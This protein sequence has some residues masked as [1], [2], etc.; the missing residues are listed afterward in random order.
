MLRGMKRRMEISSEEEMLAEVDDDEIIVKE[1]RDEPLAKRARTEEGSSLVQ[2]PQ[3]P[4]SQPIK[5]E[6]TLE[7]KSTIKVEV[8]EENAADVTNNALTWAALA[9]ESESLGSQ[10]ELDRVSTNV[11][12]PPPL[13]NDALYLYWIDMHEEP[14]Q[15]GTV[16]IFGKVK[17]SFSIENYNKLFVGVERSQE[18][19]L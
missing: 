11:P 15:P 10:P 18:K 4:S 1:G 8:P 13:I 3:K 12:P 5:A 14:A 9:A 7:A 6:S 16:Y 17:F 2:S 19:V